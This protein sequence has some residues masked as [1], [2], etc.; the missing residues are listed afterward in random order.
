MSSTAKSLIILG[1][2]FEFYES[3]LMQHGDGDFDAIE[4]TA[5]VG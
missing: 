3:A 1:F 5:L 2:F 4:F